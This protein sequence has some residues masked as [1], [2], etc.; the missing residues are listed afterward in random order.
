MIRRL[1]LAF[2]VLSAGP[3]PAVDFSF[4]YV[5]IPAA[6]QFIQT[7]LAES[8]VV[9]LQKSQEMGLGAAGL[10]FGQNL[11]PLFEGWPLWLGYE[12]GFALPSGTRSFDVRE[13]ILNASS[14]SRNARGEG[15]SIEWGA[16]CVPLF[17][18]LGIIPSSPGITLN[19]Q[20]GMGVVIMD[21]RQDYIDSE[22][23]GGG[24]DELV[25]VRTTSS[26]LTAAAFAFQLGAGL[27]VPVTETLSTRLSGGVLWI[28][29]TDFS[30][31]TVTDSDTFVEGLQVGGLGFMVRLGLSAS[32]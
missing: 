4:E 3:A 18:T 12:A 27:T 28:A 31:E 9:P 19:A 1:A 16:L 32:L 15:D 10:R 22:Y 17:V 14:L 5:S 23:S 2:A 7:D 6:W 26:H 20:A 8:P 13:N 30:V 25:D 24:L 11:P 21:V 29:D